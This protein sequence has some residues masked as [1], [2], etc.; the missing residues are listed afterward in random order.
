[1]MALIAQCVPEQSAATSRQGWPMIAKGGD[2]K[3]EAPDLR[4]E[5]S[6]LL[7]MQQPSLHAARGICT[8]VAQCSGVAVKFTKM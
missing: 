1:M 8:E 6:T 5:L 7:G 4:D 3:Y 2:W